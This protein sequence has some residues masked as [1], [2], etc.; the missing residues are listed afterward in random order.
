MAS[1]KSKL[2]PGEVTLTNC[3]LEPIHLINRSQ[4]HGVLL[5]CNPSDKLITGFSSNGPDLFH[6][7]ER[8]ELPLKIN[9]ILDDKIIHAIFE[10]IPS[11]GANF[12]KCLI[13]NVPHVVIYHCSGETLILEFEPLNDDI[14]PVL[15][16]IELSHIFSVLNRS[17]RVQ[18]MCDKAA[19][20]IR[21]FAGYDR[22][23]IYKFDEHWNGEVVSES[24]QA[25]LESWLGLRYPATD[26]PSQARALFLRQGVRI[27]SDVSDQTQSLKNLGNEDIDFSLSEL[28]A[29]SP[30]HIEYLTNMKVAATM[31]AAIVFDE[32]LWGLVACHHYSP[33]F[34]DYFK[35]MSCKFLTQVFSNQ[36]G[37]RSTNTNLEKMNRSNTVRAKIIERISAHRNIQVGLSKASGDLLSLN[38]SSGGAVYFDDELSTFG[39]APDEIKILNLFNWLRKSSPGDT[40]LTEN[41]EGVFSKGAEIKSNV[42]GVLCVFLSSERNDA[43]LWFKPERIKIVEWG[44][45]PEKSVNEEGGRLSPRKSFDAWKAEQSGHS[46]PWEDYEIASAKALKDHL[47]DIILK[48]YDEM[49]RLNKKLES[50]NN[51]LES[52]SYSVSHDLRAPLRGISGF[53]QILLEK[54]YDALD[55]F[56]KSALETIASSSTKMN[57][58]ID[59]ILSFSGLGKKSTE[60][61]TFEMVDLVKE[62]LEYLKAN[63]FY[64]STSITVEKE[65]GSL[66]G[67][68]SMIFQLMNNLLSN[69]LK[70]S[71]KQ[72]NPEVHIGREQKAFYVRDNGIGF[73]KAHSKKIFGV[74]KRLVSDEYEGSGIGLAIS[75]RVIE[76]HHGRIWVESE[77]GKGT[78]FYFTI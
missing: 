69:A 9:Q 14:D 43:I 44:G 58:L 6:E 50:V 31:T 36:L 63:E 8:S 26:I 34:I 75:K 25:K 32:D 35:R 29:V 51:E 74:F 72:S 47:S 7:L 68:R 38:E 56:G 5:I 27:I 24:K 55:D 77:P 40:F 52:F 21:D 37:L 48:K 46:E 62:V 67:D 70:Y 78:T 30:I 11:E 54:Y 19:K 66:T 57:S 65:L 71:A 10:D 42:S 22:V 64:K 73:D 28:R 53:S 16:Q 60:L 33:R 23:M 17:T 59:D 13:G 20:L 45:N 2:Y 4:S 49:L 1:R 61:S 12:K 18:D 76:K 3:D 39:D 15:Q 41:L